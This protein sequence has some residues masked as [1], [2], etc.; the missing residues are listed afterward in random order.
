MVGGTGIDV[1]NLEN[2]VGGANHETMSHVHIKNISADD[3]IVM[4]TSDL[5]RTDEALSDGLVT[6]EKTDGSSHMLFT[7]DEDMLRTHLEDALA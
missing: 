3:S 2:V 4:D 7:D 1:I 6:V 5:L